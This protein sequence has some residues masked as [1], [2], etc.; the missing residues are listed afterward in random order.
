MSFKKLLMAAI[1]SL[2]VVA[3]SLNPAKAENIT[4]EVVS[5]NQ[6]GTL[7]T[8][9]NG[10]IYGNVGYFFRNRTNINYENDNKTDSFSLLDITYPLRKGFDAVAEGQ[11][12]NGQPFDPRLGAQYFKNFNNGLSVY[13]LITRN[14]NRNPN[15]EFTTV[16]GY[17]KNF[18][19][20]WKLVG[21]LEE[22]INIGDKNYNYDVTRLRLG[23]GKNEIIIGPSLDISGIES[24]EGPKYAPGGFI[25]VKIK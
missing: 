2:Y 19:D 16:L 12:Q 15:T 7:D 6:V 1:A 23:I 21:R 8:K 24:K 4:G 20:K 13:A 9:I 11:F 25:T 18:D 17:T 3:S 10:T 5:G 14:F 22:I